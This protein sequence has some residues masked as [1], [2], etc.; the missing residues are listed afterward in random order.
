MVHDLFMDDVV[1]VRLRASLYVRVT[2]E[3]FITILMH[4]RIRETQ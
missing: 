1:S 4:A 2:P 3:L